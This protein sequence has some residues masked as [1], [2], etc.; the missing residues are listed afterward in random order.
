MIVDDKEMANLLN[1]TFSNLGQYFDNI[2]DEFPSIL[3]GDSSF[4]FSPITVKDCYIIINELKPNKPTGP[5]KVPA[6]ATMDGK[7]WMEILTS[8]LTFILN[9]CINESVFPTMLKRATITPIFKK[10]DILHPKNYR[11]ISISTTFS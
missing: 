11:P 6:W 4:S 9:E 3:P 5:C 1:L 10:D 2:K 7:Q 8:H